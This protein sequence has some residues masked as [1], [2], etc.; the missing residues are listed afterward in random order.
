MVYRSGFLLI[1]TTKIHWQIQS[2][3]WVDE[4]LGFQ[5]SVLG[6]F[7]IFFVSFASDT[8]CNHL[9]LIINVSDISSR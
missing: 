2:A 1:E 3:T 9:M 5:N 8:S 4:L 6:D 7:H